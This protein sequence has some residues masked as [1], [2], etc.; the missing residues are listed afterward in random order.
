MPLQRTC[1]MDGCTHPLFV[2]GLCN[3]HRIRLRRHGSTD[4]PR[5]HRPAAHERVWRFVSLRDGC[6]EWTGA[7][8]SSGI[9]EYGAFR[10]VGRRVLAHRYIYELFYG[11]QE[12]GLDHLC[13]N[14]RCVRPDHLE[15]VPQSV[16]NLRGHGPPARNAR[17]T[18]C[19]RG[20][21]FAEHGYIRPNGYRTCRTCRA[22]IRDGL[23]VPEPGSC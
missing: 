15:P 22:L 12:L 5:A 3:M 10:G 21:A 6:W 20:H 11:P 13:A 2:K 8:A 1:S 7:L 16:N 17:K 14:T 9:G 4:D 23:V 18:H 19:R